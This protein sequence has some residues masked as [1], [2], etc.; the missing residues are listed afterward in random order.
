M[1]EFIQIK[2]IKSSYKIFANI[3]HP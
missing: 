2:I 3:T 1:E